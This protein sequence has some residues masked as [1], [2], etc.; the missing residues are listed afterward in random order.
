MKEDLMECPNCGVTLMDNSKFCNVCG[1]KLEG[2]LNQFDA[3]DKQENPYGSLEQ[4]PSQRGGAPR[5]RQMP[6]DMHAYGMP[7]RGPNNYYGQAFPQKAA[8]NPMGV[9]GF[10]IALVGF[11]LSWVPVLNWILWILGIVFSGIG[12]FR[13][14]KGLAIAGV[15]ISFL[16]L[17]IILILIGTI[18]GG[19]GAAASS[20]SLL[21]M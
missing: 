14:P 7:N 9:A 5:Q 16:D 15:A 2:D 6:S 1:E 13:E 19:I 17:L 3:L 4:R 10:V 8:S 18:F 20:L 11:F 21:A 12:I